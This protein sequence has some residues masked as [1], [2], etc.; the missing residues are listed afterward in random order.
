M[1]AEIVDAN[2]VERERLAALLARLN[3]AELARPLGGGWTVAMALAH[4]AFWDRRGRILLEHW[5]RGEVPPFAEPDW[6]DNVANE[7][8]EP[9]WKVLPA[10]DCVRLA[11]EAA[12]G[13]DHTVE[14]LAPGVAQAI[15]AR[16][17]GWRLRRGNHRREHV[18]Q[19]ERTLTPNP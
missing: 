6:Y 1:N 19:I 2:K 4:L 5:E 17:E 9:E 12:E 18:D 8:L 16:G 7:A 10:R 13:I 15:E 14:R 11:L 3:D